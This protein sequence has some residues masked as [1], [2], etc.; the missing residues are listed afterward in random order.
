MVEN[1][2][3][4]PLISDANEKKVAAKGSCTLRI[5]PTQRDIQRFIFA[6][7][8]HITSQRLIGLPGILY[9]RDC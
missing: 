5:N 2:T 3:E 8:N 1:G 9:Q 7:E 6:G 4:F